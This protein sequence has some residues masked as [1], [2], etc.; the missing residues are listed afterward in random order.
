MDLLKSKSQARI[1]E[2][3]KLSLFYQHELQQRLQKLDRQKIKWEKKRENLSLRSQ[4]L[5]ESIKHKWSK[6]NDKL[7]TEKEKYCN[8]IVKLLPEWKKALNVNK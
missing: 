8:I 6:T 2:N 3:E 5:Q 1:E 4:E 7:N